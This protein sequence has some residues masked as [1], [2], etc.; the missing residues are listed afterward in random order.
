MNQYNVHPADDGTWA[1]ALVDA[2]GKVED[3]AGPFDDRPA[4]IEAARVHRGDKRTK[5]YFEDGSE[6]GVL[7]HDRGP[8]ALYIYN[9]DGSLYGEV[10]R[11][12]RDSGPA[13][14]FSIGAAGETTQAVNRG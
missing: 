5:L 10:D 8:E 7:I 1:W 13:Q 2:D 12:I 9:A 3:E 6:A 4:A 14:V 11:P